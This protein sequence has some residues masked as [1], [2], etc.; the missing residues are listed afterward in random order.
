MW[1]KD[2]EPHKQDAPLD[3]IHVAPRTKDVVFRCRDHGW[4][5]E[6]L[7]GRRFDQQVNMCCVSEDNEE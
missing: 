1:R 6:T 7:D 2:E 3:N 4:Q 5:R